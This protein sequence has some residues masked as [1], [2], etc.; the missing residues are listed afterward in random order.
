MLLKNSIDVTLVDEDV[1]SKVIVDHDH[2]ADCLKNIDSL[3]VACHSL[4]Q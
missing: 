2:V 4:S 1:K 3:L